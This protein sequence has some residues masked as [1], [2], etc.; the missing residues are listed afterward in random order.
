MGSWHVIA[1]EVGLFNL[2]LPWRRD[3]SRSRV[4]QSPSTDR[5]RAEGTDQSDQGFSLAP[6]R[7]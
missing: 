3:R 4:E 1:W 7:S 2:S 5:A 6:F